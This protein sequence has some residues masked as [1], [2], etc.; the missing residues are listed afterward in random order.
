[1]WNSRR[2]PGKLKANEASVCHSQGR[3]NGNIWGLQ[4]Y[5]GQKIVDGTP[6]EPLEFPWRCI[7]L[8]DYDAPGG[9][10]FCSCTIL[11]PE[12]ILTAAH[13]TYGHRPEKILVDAGANYNVVCA[14]SS[15]KVV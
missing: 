6:A 11:S 10:G 7:L 9:F 5:S 4:A 15:V 3:I 14:I 8:T 1:M 13:C 2:K 12:W